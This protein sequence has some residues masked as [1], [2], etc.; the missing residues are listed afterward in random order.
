MILN[1]LFF[2]I[3]GIFEVKVTAY[4]QLN[5]VTASK[6]FKV[7]DEVKGAN[8]FIS[9]TT[10][11]NGEE[12]MISV[13]VDSGTEVFLEIDFGDGRK[14]NAVIEDARGGSGVFHNFTHK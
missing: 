8:L 1:V 11:S 10:V 13:H 4:N 5:S 7:L 6:S 3:L 14:E 12:T 9:K 2:D